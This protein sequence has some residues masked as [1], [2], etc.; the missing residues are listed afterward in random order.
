MV[1]KATELG[2]DLLVVV[3]E[4][5][6]KARKAAFEQQNQP[7]QMNDYSAQIAANRQAMAQQAAYGQSYPVRPFSK[8]FLRL[9]LTRS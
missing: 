7:M 4:E 3:R 6:E 8:V 1:D 9:K 5:H 2:K